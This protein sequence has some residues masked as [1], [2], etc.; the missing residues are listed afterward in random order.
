M[1]NFTFLP[2][3][4]KTG[5]A[6]KADLDAVEKTN[7]NCLYQKLNPGLPARNPSLYRLS[8]KQIKDRN[9]NIH[10]IE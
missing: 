9:Q 2:T 7:K 5:W 10:E 8:Y 6:P 4:Q 3:G 1:N